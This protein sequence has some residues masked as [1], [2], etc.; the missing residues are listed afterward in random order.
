MAWHPQRAPWVDRRLSVVIEVE[1]PHVVCKGSGVARVSQREGSESGSDNF[2]AARPDHD[3]IPSTCPM[4]RWVLFCG[5]GPP[6][7]DSSDRARVQHPDVLARTVIVV[8]RLA[9]ATTHLV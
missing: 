7:R 1:S 2:Q 8:A 6:L 4:A 5:F 3:F 9:T